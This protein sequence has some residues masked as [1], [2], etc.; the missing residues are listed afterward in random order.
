MATF[1]ILPAELNCTIAVAN[2]FGMTLD[3][4]TDLTGFTWSAEVFEITR[5]V[6][7]SYPGGL[8]VRGPTAAAITVTVVDAASG[9]L[10]LSMQ[11]AVVSQLSES[12]TYRWEL[13][14]VA[15]GSVTRTYISGSFSVRT[16]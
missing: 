12:Q 6:N 11:E 3:F 2:E 9:Q 5:T 13:T 7:S 14:G 10:S 1:E 16:P 15:P 8:N 4:S